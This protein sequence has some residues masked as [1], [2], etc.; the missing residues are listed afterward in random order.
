MWGLPDVCGREGFVLA[1]KEK[2]SVAKLMFLFFREFWLCGAFL[3]FF[4][5][6]CTQG[7]RNGSKD[8]YK[9]I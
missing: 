7:I 9:H 4:Q 6:L 8:I 2:L 5:V 1:G 3:L